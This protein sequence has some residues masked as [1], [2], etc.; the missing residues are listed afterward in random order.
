MTLIESN[1]KIKNGVSKHLLREAVRNKLPKEIYF[2]YDKKGFETPMQDW[3]REMR[4][5]LLS[6]IK[7]AGFSFLNYKGIE[8]SNPHSVAH[9]KMLFKLY[10]LNKWAKTFQ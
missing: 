9:N 8:N 2:R 6:E 10:V 1:K 3:M 5:I 4:P 7:E